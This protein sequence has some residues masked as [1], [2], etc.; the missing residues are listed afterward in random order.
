MW[1]WC[2]DDPSAPHTP[3]AAA[4]GC[5][6]PP[7]QQGAGLPVRWFAKR[8]IKPA[9]PRGSGYSVCSY[10]GVF[11]MLRPLLAILL[12]AA[13]LPALAAVQ[14]IPLNNRLAEDVLPVVRSLLGQDG[15][16]SAYG[17]QL[18]VNADPA[19]IDA[20]ND[21]LRQLDTPARRLLISVDTDDSS[22]RNANGLAGNG[23]N[24][25]RIIQ[26]GTANRSGGVQQVQAMEG[27]P[28]L[29]QIGQSVPLTS[30]QSDAY[31]YPQEST[32]YRDVTQGFYVTASVTGET[33]HLAI[34]TNND[35]MSSDRHDVV[36]IQSTNTKLSG[37]LGE[38][39]PLAAVNELSQANRRSNTRQYA[40]QGRKDVTVRVRVDT[41][42]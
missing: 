15:S 19:R 17:N 14:V 10:S 7:A 6:D 34:S 1:T 23:G 33:V 2:V 9:Q 38:W 24:Q 40:T 25:G 27:S 12:L 29:I 31:G 20:V 35:R 22:G 30:S 3:V 13:S 39:I 37:K 8:P 16:V 28:A 26:Y 42:E 36:D 4:E 18:V 21:L 41:L 5:A 11:A 32:Q